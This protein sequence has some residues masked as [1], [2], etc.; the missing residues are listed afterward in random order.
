MQLKFPILSGI[1][2]T[3]ICCFCFSILQAQKTINDYD[4]QWKKVESFQKKG[5]TKSA[6]QEVEIIY[7]DAKKNNNDAQIIKTLLF[8]I[9]LQQNI[10]EDASVKSIDS[11]QQEIRMAKEPAKSILQ[12]ITAQM[13]WNYFQQNRY[14]IYQ[15]TN[16]INFDKKD[17][18]TWTSDELH[19]K[20][21]ELYLASLK[22][23]PL[24]QHTK[25]EPFEAIIL[26]GNVRNL[27]PTLFDLLAHRALDYFKNDERDIT[28]PTYAFE[29]NDPVAFA[30]VNEFINEKFISK[31]SASLHQKSLIIYQKLLAFHEKDADPDALIDADLDRINFVNQYGVM[32]DKDSLYINVLSHLSKKY[33]ANPLSAQATFLIAQL[34]YNKA[35]EANRNKDSSDYTIIKAKEILNNIAHKFPK[36]E[37]GINA[38]NLLKTISHPFLNLTTEKI[39]VPDQPFRTLVNYQNLNSVYFRLL[40]LTP[41]LKKSLQKEFDNDKLFRKLVSIKNFKTWKQDLPKTDD[42]FSHSAEV[43]IDAL[44]VGEYALIGSA[45]ENFSQD[46]N[47]LAAQYFYVSDISFINSGVQYFVLNRTTGQP[48]SGAKVNVWNQKYD[49]STRINALTNQANFSTDKNG[50]FRLPPSKND[51]SSQ[52]IRLD[53][54]YKN[55]RLFLDDYQYVDYNYYNQNEDVK[56]N[57]TDQ[58]KFDE[59]NAKVFLFTDRS[60]YRPGQTVYFKGIGVTKEFKTK[61]SILLQ[62]KDSLKI[63]FSDA[64]NQKID[65]VNVLLNDFGSFNG[66]FKIPENKL[67]GEFAIDVNHY[68]NSSVLFSLEEYKRPKFY[69]EFEKAKGNFRLG[70]TVSRIFPLSG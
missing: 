12:S 28:R 50:Y 33:A 69:T 45:D 65:S 52:N 14:K 68:K 55:D 40:S 10:E 62:S 63:I 9:N 41:D 27:Q 35:I 57:Y 7:N 13:Y 24:L 42:Y 30:P 36:S 67:N 5:L 51:N 3:I 54:T 29:I 26:K 31:D 4:A 32:E 61:K 39:N 1:F 44:P 47:P 59:E 23:E 16:T 46:A 53:I 18:V 38:Q 2:I 11:L 21:A 48:L 17:I 19:Q 64:N 56:N 58:N 34:I 49:Y 20:I 66:K 6:L 70:D 25:L 15:R 37:G 43:K 22:N 60:I 8:K